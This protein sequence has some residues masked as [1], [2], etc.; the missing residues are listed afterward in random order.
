MLYLNS[1]NSFIQSLRQV[2]DAGLA[3]NIIQPVL[4]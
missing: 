4:V 3:Q 1:E 2:L